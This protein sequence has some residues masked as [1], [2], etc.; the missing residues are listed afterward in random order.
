MKDTINKNYLRKTV[1]QTIIYLI[2]KNYREE[3]RLNIKF[4]A[5][6]NIEILSRTLSISVEIDKF[7]MRLDNY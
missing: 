1:T 6:F 2:Q 4:Y 5:L 7:L 3:N